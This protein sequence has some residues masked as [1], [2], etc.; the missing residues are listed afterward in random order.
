MGPPCRHPSM[1]GPLPCQT[2]GSAH[3]HKHSR[4]LTTTV[5]TSQPYNSSRGHYQRKLI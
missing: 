2:W 4:A 3:C 5:L 1:Y